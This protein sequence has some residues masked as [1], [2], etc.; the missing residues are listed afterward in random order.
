MA[1]IPEAGCS[2]RAVHCIILIP[3]GSEKMGE[4]LAEGPQS[5][6]GAMENTSQS[7]VEDAVQN[8]FIVLFC[9]F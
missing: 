2:V 6:A 4:C 8:G 7:N 3:A 9:G 1:Q 5:F